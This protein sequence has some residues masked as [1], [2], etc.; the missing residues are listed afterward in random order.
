MSPRIIV[1]AISA[2]YGVCVLALDATNNP[3]TLLVGLALL[4]VFVAVDGWQTR[5]ERRHAD[6]AQVSRI[7]HRQPEGPS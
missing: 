5:T 2:F 7:I 3:A 4:G 1:G 6:A